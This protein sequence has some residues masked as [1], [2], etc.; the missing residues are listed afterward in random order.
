MWTFCCIA[1]LIALMHCAQKQA[2]KADRGAAETRTQYLF[3]FCISVEQIVGAPRA[4]SVV[5]Q[6]LVHVP[7]H[8]SRYCR[9]CRV[10]RG[11]SIHQR[12]NRICAHP[13]CMQYTD[14]AGVK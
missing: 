13:S 1:D 3:D 8:A 12:Y 10:S 11:G 9:V 5:A 7:L 6:H 4:V 2:A 14:E